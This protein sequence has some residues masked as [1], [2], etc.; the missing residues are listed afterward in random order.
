MKLRLSLALL[1]AAGSPAFAQPKQ[2]APPKPATP[3]TPLPAA[4][5]QQPTGGGGQFDQE[6]DALFAGGG[7]TADEAAVRASKVSPTVARRAA[8]VEVAIANLQIAELARIPQVSAKASYTRLSPLDPLVFGPG[9]PPLEFPDNAY[10]LD[11]QIGIPLSEYIFRF[12]KII[13]AAKLGVDAVTVGKHASEVNAGQEARLAYYEWMRAQLQVLVAERQYTQV[14]TVTKQVR[15]LAEAQRVSRADLMRVESQEASAEQAVN[16][17]RR[18]A[19]LREEQ[20]RILIGA[21]DEKLTLGEDPRK[22]VPIP[23]EAGLDELV[24]K[25][26]SQRLEFKS[27]DLGIAAKDK[28]REAELANKIP[29]LSAFASANYD[30]P[31]Q[32]VFPQE[33]KFKFTWMAGVQLTWTLNDALIATKNENRIRAEQSELVADRESLLRGTRIELLSAQQ[34][35]QVALLN[36]GTSAKGLAAAEESYRVRRELLNAERATAVELVDAETELTRARIAAVNAR[37]D[38]RV[39]IA[40]L[41]HALGEDVRR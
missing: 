40:Q 2:P 27:L 39:A 24:S 33:E 31:N 29:H 16:Q 38:L 8:E 25:A 13:D 28:Q 6:L 34:A 7:L 9:F 17:L 26:K 22:E 36:F 3:P 10:A 11:A 4:P 41:R 1:L 12:P 30:N 5:Q 19:A 35:V 18:L 14:Q 32:R 21:G 20:V 37:V 15:A 23:P